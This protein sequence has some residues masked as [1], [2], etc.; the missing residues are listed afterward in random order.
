MLDSDSLQSP[1]STAHAALVPQDAITGFRVASVSLIPMS[2]Q[3]G[4]EHDHGRMR[5]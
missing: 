1:A 2:P 3:G 5:P 4:R